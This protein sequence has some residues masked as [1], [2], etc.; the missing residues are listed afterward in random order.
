MRSTRARCDRPCPEPSSTSRPP[1]RRCARSARTCTHRGAEA[2]REPQR[3]VRRRPPDAAAG[4]GRGARAPRSTSLD[5]DVRAA[6]EESIRRARHRARGPAPHRHARRRSSRAARSPSAGCRSTGSAS[7]SPAVVAV[8]ASSVVMNVVPAQVAGVAVAS[9]SPARRS[10][11]TRQF[12]GCPHPTDPRRVRAARRRRGVRRRR[13]PGDRD[14]RLRRQRGRRRARLRAGRPGHRARATSTSSPPSGCSRACIGIDSE[15]GPDRDRDPR[16]RHRR[17]GARRRRPDQ[18]GRARPAGRRRSWSPTR[19]PLADA[20][21]AELDKQVAGDQA[22]RADP[23]RARRPPVRHRPGRRPRAGP[24]RRQRLRRRAPR[25]PDRATPPRSPPGSATPARSSSG[26]YAPVSARRLLRRLQP[27]AADRRLR[28]PLQRAVG[29]V[30]PAR[31][32]VVDYDEARCARSPTTSSR[33]PRPRTC[34]PTARPSR[35]R[36]GGRARLVTCASST[37]AARRPARAGRRTAPRSSTCPV[38]LNINEN[39][40]P[41]PPTVVADIAAAVRR[42]RAQPQPLPRPRVHRPARG[43]AAYLAPRPASTSTPS[44]SGPATAPTR[45]CCTLLQAFGGPGRTALGFTPGV[46]DAPD[47]HRARPAPRWVDGLRGAAGA[48]RS[49]STPS[50]R[51]A[52]VARAPTRT[53]SSSARRTTPPA[54]RSA[55]D[56][57]AAV[58]RRRDRA[59]VVVV[60]EA[61]AEFARPGTPS[62]L[63]LLAGRPRL[64]VTRTMSK[65]FALAG[66]RL[67]YLAADPEL[68]DALRL[69]RLP[70][71]LSSP[72]QAVAR[73]ALAHADELLGTV[74]VDQGPA[75]PDRRR[76]APRSACDPVAERRELRALRRP[77]RRARHLAGAA[78][79]GRPGPRR[80]HRPLSSGD[81]RAPPPRPTPSSTAMGRLAATSPQEHPH[82]R[83]GR[84]STRPTRHRT[85]SI[86]APPSE[87]SVELELDLDGTGASD[88]STGVRFYDHM[89]RRLAKH[90]LID[91][92][93]QGHRRRRR[94]RAPHRRGRRDRPRRRAARGARRQARHLA[95]S[96]TPR[97]R[98]TRRWCRPSSTSPAAPTSCTR[99]SPRARQYV[100]IG[101][102]YA[103]S[104]TR[105]VLES[106]AYHAGIALHVRVL[107]GRDPHHIVEAQFKA[108]ARALRAAVARD[109]RVGG[110]PSAKG[111]L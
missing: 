50:R 48:G 12:A 100:L 97:C 51:A 89:L 22:R 87:S 9:P 110:I 15:A 32:H 90:S 85:A 5:P 52:Q 69:V 93:R 81:G 91:L 105:H 27:R 82:D 111:S 36:F 18:P 83:A 77:R 107:A 65:A 33:S 99:A 76:A 70:Y 26:R 79:A 94:R 95:A 59:R 29:A 45:C 4:A 66:G 58:L 23:H 30:V 64:V 19:E 102:T 14:V 67:G 106:F 54:P 10:A 20:V 13:R 38:R 44:R 104:L 25:D 71:H 80:R 109:P 84:P 17:P 42:G 35:A 6:L 8:L 43:L 75:R 16:R 11:T 56:V 92:T 108:V 96:A 1:S 47:H 34:P 7:T 55:L 60:D 40:Y 86:R 62:A 57:V 24:R 73:A 46:L 37:A 78:R 39:P 68:V 72:T 49:T 3:A 103:G 74:E 53:S 41:C 63:T 98:S 28:L 101:G 21:E 61:Y 31:L 88:V 2:L